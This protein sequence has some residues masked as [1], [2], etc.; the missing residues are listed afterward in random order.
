MKVRGAGGVGR[1]YRH[2]I[3]Q[4]VLYREFI[5]QA[6]PLHFWFERYG[7]DAAACQAAVVIPEF[8]SGTG[9]RWRPRLQAL[10]DLFDV[11]LVEVDK[12]SA[13]LP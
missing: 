12:K 2:A 11:E 4:A 9:G 3:A 8:P 13:E 10:C 1:Y 6:R 7:L 5:R